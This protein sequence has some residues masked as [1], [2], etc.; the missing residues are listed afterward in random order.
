MQ[1]SEPTNAR[2]INA[3]DIVPSVP[4]PRDAEDEVRA[5]RTPHPSGLNRAQRREAYKRHKVNGR[6]RRGL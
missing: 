2:V 4:M 3:E 1:P 5:G 6:K